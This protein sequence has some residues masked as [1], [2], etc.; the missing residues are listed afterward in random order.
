G[1]T[2][3]AVADPFGRSAAPT[4]RAQAPAAVAPVSRGELSART[5]ENGT[6]GYAGSYQVVN[7]ADG[8]AT[9]L[10]AV[11]DVVRQGQPL[12]EVDG[13]PVVLLHGAYVPVYRTLSWGMQGV[14]VR[15]LNA[16]LVELGHT[17]GGRLDPESDY[18][19]RA[20]YNALRELQGAVGL[21]KTGDLPLGQ[22]VFVQAEEL[23][24]TEVAVV[25][26]AGVGPGPVLEASSTERQ[27]SVALNADRQSSVAV[28]DRVEITLPTGRTTGGTVSEVGKVATRTGTA[29]TV[30]VRIKPADPAATGQLDQ[31]PVRVS[32]VS[33]TVR[34][35]LSVPVNALLALAG[36]GYAVEV[37]DGGGAHR[38]VAVETGLFDDSAGKV[39]VSG[40]GLEAGQNV[41][42]PSS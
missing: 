39:Q 5:Q 41:V 18:F 2:V 12:Y 1:G 26:G 13:E 11:G 33:D 21:E 31:A 29:T 25:P 24:I 40:E 14:D 34:D 42:V 19:G 36:G 35:V 30:D 15:Q 22:A 9:R 37:V 32:I 20:T 10:P 28:G 3:L 6:L 27:V 4:A 17:D 8:T 16:A 23:R 7:R 38:L